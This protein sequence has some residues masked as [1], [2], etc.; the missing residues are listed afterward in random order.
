MKK[1]LKLFKSLL[2]LPMVLMMAVPGGIV[3]A[4]ESSSMS[5]APTKNYLVEPGK[6]VKDKLTIRNPDNELELKLNLRVVDFTFSDESGTP[7]F[8]L[9]PNAPQTDWSLKPFMNLPDT[10]NI[11]P[12]QTK[13]VDVSVTMPDGQAGGSYYSAIVYS[14][15][16]GEGLNVGLSASVSTLVFVEVPGSVKEDMQLINLGAYNKTTSQD[17]SGYVKF[18]T[19]E[20]QNVAYTLVNN[21]N[22]AERPIGSIHF[23]NLLFNREFSI[24]DINPTGARALR[25]Q[26]RIFITCIKSKDQRLKFEDQNTNI[27]GCVSPELWPGVYKISADLFYGVNG[28]PTQ[29]LTR[30]AYLWYL[31]WW[32]IVATIIVLAILAYFVWKFVRFVRQKLGLSSKRDSKTSDSK[33]NSRKVTERKKVGSKKRTH[34]DSDAK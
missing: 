7:K 31:P 13:S 2:I 28:N 18:T 14:S 33:T 32:F 29:E 5:I 16:A 21:G 17:S 30:T 8:Y 11:A 27:T 15:G 3:N 1:R 23:K 19:N 10:V 24:D 22:I 12:G 26:T 20:P 25:G 4:A 9:D 6:T 34:S